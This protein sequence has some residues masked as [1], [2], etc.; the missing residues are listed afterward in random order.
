MGV[1]GKK[2]KRVFAKSAHD[3]YP[4]PAKAVPALVPHLSGY[5]SY[6]EPCC[7]NGALVSHL[8]QAS[9]LVPAFVSDLAP[10]REDWLPDRAE[11]SAVMSSALAVFE[12]DAL[13]LSAGDFLDAGIMPD[14]PVITNPP[15][16]RDGYAKNRHDPDNRQ[17]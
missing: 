4:T 14:V 13:A 12:R 6:T 1:I 3:F 9:G 5:K 11:S 2:T 17:H 16:T 15:W 10:Q 7:G 8:Y